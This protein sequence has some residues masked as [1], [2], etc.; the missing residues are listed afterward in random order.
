MSKS[1][2]DIIV[3]RLLEKIQSENKLPWQKPFAFASINW[4]T[5]KEYLGINKFLLDGGEY[6]TPKQLEG[7]NKK[8]GKNYW[9]EKGT[10]YEIVVYYGPSFKPLTKEQEEELAKKGSAS[11]LYSKLRKKGNELLVQSWILRYYRVYNI[12]HIKDKEGN[13][14][15]I[16]L[17]KIFEE[18]ITAPEEIREKYCNATGVI[19]EEKPSDSAYYTEVGDKVVIPEMQYFNSPEAF[20]R[21]LFHELSHSTGIETRLNRECFKKY[22]NKIEERSREELIAEVGSLLL[23]TEAGFREDTDLAKNSDSYILSWIKW[24]KENTYEV[25]LGM[26]QAEK[27]KNYILNGGTLPSYTDDMET[28]ASI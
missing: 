26:Q 23:S 11:H 4:S 9:F 25:V 16:K 21:V 15:P 3:E 1:V 27:V 19:V 2:Q 8:M 24:M 6:I 12:K 7:Y 13:L 5:E 10:P 18:R 17:G 20:Y 14:L 28:E 22:H